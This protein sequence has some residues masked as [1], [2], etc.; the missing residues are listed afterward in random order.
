M[1]GSFQYSRLIVAPLST[2]SSVDNAAIFPFR[3]HGVRIERLIPTWAP[4]GIV[5]SMLSPSTV[6]QMYKPGCV[7]R[8][9]RGTKTYSSTSSV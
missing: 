2:P 4:L 5:G 1:Y 6:M 3:A 7:L 9:C 8:T